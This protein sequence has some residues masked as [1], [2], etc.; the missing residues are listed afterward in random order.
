[1]ANELSTAGITIGYAVESTSGTRPST[2]SSIPNVKSIG[3][4][5]PDPATYDVTDLSDLV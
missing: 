1:M 5:N 4:M 2:F 3:D